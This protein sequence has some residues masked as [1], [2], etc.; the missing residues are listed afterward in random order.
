MG[1]LKRLR[2]EKK[3]EPH[4]QTYFEVPKVPKDPEHPGNPD[5]N[6]MKLGT[7]LRI[8]EVPK[9]FQRGSKGVPKR[10]EQGIFVWMNYQKTSHPR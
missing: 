10:K 9:R 5:I 8:L 6:W 7:P 1:I 4:T 2:K 3:T